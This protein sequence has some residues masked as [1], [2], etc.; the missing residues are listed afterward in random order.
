M[1]D[2]GAA[3][4]DFGE[5]VAAQFFLFLE[6]EWAMVGGN[7]LQMIALQSVPQFFLMP[8]F[9][10]RRR[11]N[12]LRAFE[13]GDV[14]VFEGKIEILRTGFRIDGKSAITGLAHFFERVVAA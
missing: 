3:V 7:Y 10:Q 5:V 12:V 6:A 14:D 13:A 11:E 4:G 1:L 9:A 2:A 8:F